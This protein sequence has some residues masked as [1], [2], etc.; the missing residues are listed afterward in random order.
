MSVTFK[1]CAENPIVQPGL[2]DWRRAVVFNPGVLLDDDG[3][4]Y[5][6][7]RAAGQLRPFHCCIGMLESNDGVQF[8]HVQDTPVL[9]PAMA[10]SKYGSVQD[11][12]VVKIDGTYYMTFAYRPYAWNSN[13]T[14]LGVPQSS[15]AQY[16]G[17]SGDPKENM[18]RSGIAVSKDRVHWE[19]KCWPTP[20]ELDDRDVILFPEKING[21]YAMLR[22]PLQLVGPQHGTDQPGIW[23]S[24]SDD[25]ARWSEPVLLARPEATWEGGRIG[26]AAPPIR[27]SKGW[28]AFYHGVEDEYPP[29]RRVVYRLGAMLLDLN[30]PR[31]VLAR[32]QRFIMEPQ[33]YYEKFGLYI[34]NVIFPTA[35]VVKDGLVYLYYGVCDTAIALATAPLDE[36]LAHVWNRG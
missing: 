22:R 18:T 36:L 17:F 8:K 24:F 1:R 2:Y 19:I 31:K 27:T 15:E 33:T 25:L 10:G 35:N 14:G 3:K 21:R 4:F 23:L 11:P 6:Y 28:L 30:D 16:P 34:P 20:V 26:G 7:E 5:M 32:T 13:P 29:T 9:T 12:R